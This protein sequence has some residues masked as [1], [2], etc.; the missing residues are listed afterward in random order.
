MAVKWLE[1]TRFES[2]SVSINRFGPS[3][4]NVSVTDLKIT[5][6]PIFKNGLIYI[7]LKIQKIKYFE[8]SKI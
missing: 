7:I 3:V 4:Y 2:V 8:N 6:L 1:S 5:I